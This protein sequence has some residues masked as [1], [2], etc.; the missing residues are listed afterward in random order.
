[1]ARI[2]SFPP[3]ADAGCRL[4][5]LGSMPGEAS[6]AAGQYY[7]HPRNAFWPVM[8][9]L[10]G[11]QPGVE[12]PWRVEALLGAGIALWDVLKSCERSGSL[13]S[14]ILRGSLQANDFPAFFERHPQITRVAFNGATAEQLFRRHVSHGLPA[15]LAPRSLVR[16]PSTS[17]AHASLSLEEKARQ[18]RALLG[19]SGPSVG[20]D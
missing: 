13:D 15:G 14:A 18:W 19:F 7:A 1:M 12:Y 2:S 8:G 3:I 4:L 6:L 20:T 17:P 10:I 9:Q 11:F 16:L 5:I